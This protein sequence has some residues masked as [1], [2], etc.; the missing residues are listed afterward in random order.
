MSDFNAGGGSLKLGVQV[1]IEGLSMEKV[2]LLHLLRFG[3]ALAHPELPFSLAL[4]FLDLF[5]TFCSFSVILV[6]NFDWCLGYSWNLFIWSAKDLEDTNPLRQRA[7]PNGFTELFIFFLTL[8]MYNK[9]CLMNSN[10]TVISIH[11]LYTNG[12][13]Y[14]ILLNTDSIYLFTIRTMWMPKIEC[15]LDLTLDALSSELTNF[16]QKFWSPFFHSKQF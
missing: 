4:D 8:H 10:Y 12:I 3:D 5:A 9:I 13:T 7:H 14:F 1:V 6:P 16:V 2:L 11:I 15:G